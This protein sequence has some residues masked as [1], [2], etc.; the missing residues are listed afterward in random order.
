ML[1]LHRTKHSV[2]DIHPEAAQRRLATLCAKELLIRQLQETT[3]GL[4]SPRN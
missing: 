2:G 1:I 4:A 3:F